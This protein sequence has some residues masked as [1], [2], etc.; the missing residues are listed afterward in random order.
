MGGG[1]G[2]MRS[3]RSATHTLLSVAS[4]PAHEGSAIRRNL[5]P[6]GVWKHYIIEKREQMA[7]AVEQHAAI[8]PAA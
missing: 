5:M 6:V 8:A 4:S 2:K 3:V 1:A 7:L